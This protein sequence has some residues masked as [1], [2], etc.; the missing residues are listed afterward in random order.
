MEFISSNA[1]VT[2]G[3]EPGGVCSGRGLCLVSNGSSLSESFCACEAGWSAVGDLAS[4]PSID[5]G[6]NILAV[7]IL[8]AICGVL[9]VALLLLALKRL[10]QIK[11]KL[12]LR[13][14]DT[15]VFG[16]TVIHSV[17]IAA[18]SFL[19]TA[20][21]DLRNGTLGNDLTVTTLHAFG[22]SF[23]FLTVSDEF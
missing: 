1:C 5:C 2:R 16:W 7:R 4:D 11:F 10:A 22:A 23:F 17:L 18:S 19:H 15:A 3:G 14:V 20:A 21:S 13:R 12:D 6:I 8:W 9:H